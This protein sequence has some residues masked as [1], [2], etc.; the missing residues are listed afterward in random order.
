MPSH[1]KC[2][3]TDSNLA[4]RAL[5]HLSVQAP[6]HQHRLRVSLPL[7][8]ISAT[9]ASPSSNMQ[10]PFLSRSWVTSLQTLRP[11]PAHSASVTPRVSTQAR[12]CS[13]CPDSATAAPAPPRLIPSSP[14]PGGGNRPICLPKECKLPAART[15]ALK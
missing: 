13:V 7:S 6:C 15:S 11:Y 9:L 4:F 3:R 14:F 5:R 10:S 12:P 1:R 2:C 8:Y